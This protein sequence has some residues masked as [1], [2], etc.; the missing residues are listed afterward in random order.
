VRRCLIV[1]AFLP[2]IAFAGPAAAAPSTCVTSAAATYRHTFT[3]PA[4]AATIAAVTPLCAGQSQAFSLVS[5]TVGTGSPFVYDVDHAAVDANHRS[6]TLDIAVPRCAT[7]VDAVFGT[8]VPTE[9]PAFGTVRLGAASGTGHRSSGI[10]GWYTGGTATCTPQ[11][12]VTFASD[13]DGGFTAT[14]ANRAAA[15]VAAIFL[16]D[17]HMYRVAPGTRTTVVA[18]AG[19]SLTVRDN[20][21]NTQTG[22]WS[23][24]PV[25]TQPTPTPTTA[26]PLLIPTAGP[27]SAVPTTSS[28]APT[29]TSAR[30]TT[31]TPG[32]LAAAAGTTFEPSAAAAVES[33][34]S[35]A[36][37]A[38]TGSSSGS[39]ALIALG[40][41]LI[42]GGLLILGRQIY[43]ARHT[44]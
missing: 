1:L 31:P 41:L 8:D 43:R 26:P 5:Y 42:G 24:P 29:V 12:S 10:P 13:C 38:V 14:L 19:G 36:D 23:M 7:Q 21:F 37:L 39:V 22:T 34:V 15:T 20:T 27:A 28:P 6:V 11:P 32:T 17:D 9:S 35:A 2:A 44:T 4:G 16:I 33:A 40:V 18:D 25:C 3:G 30:A